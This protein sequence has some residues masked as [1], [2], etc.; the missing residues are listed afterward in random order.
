MNLCAAVPLLL[1]LALGADAKK[2][3]LPFRARHPSYGGRAPEVLTE[4]ML[5]MRDGVKLHT[6]A[7]SPLFSSKKTWPAVIDRS[8]CE[9]N[10]TA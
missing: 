5:P 7:V 3:A 1:M 4:L 10:V 6:I 8:P 9:C 2:C